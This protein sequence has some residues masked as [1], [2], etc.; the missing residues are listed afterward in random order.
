MSQEKETKG[1]GYKG[2]LYIGRGGPLE[3][4]PAADY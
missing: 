3:G 4:Q 2:E 1:D